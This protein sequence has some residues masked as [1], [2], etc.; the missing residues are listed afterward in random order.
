MPV[1]LRPYTSAGLA[2]VSATA[3]AMTPVV[4][5]PSLPDVKVANPAVQ[6]SAAVNPIEPWLQI[7]E[8]SETNVANLA[9]LWLEAP[10]PILQ[11]VIANQLGYLQQLPDFPVILEEMVGNLQAAL[12]APFAEDLS[13]LTGSRA[14]LYDIMMNGLGTI[15]PPGVPPELQPL[16]KFQTTYLSGVLLGLVGPVINPVLALGAS[17]HTIVGN[18]T[19][20]NPDLEAALNTLINTPAAMVDSFLNGGQQIDITPLVNALGIEH[21]LD[22]LTVKLTFGGLLSGAGTMFNALD[23][24][25]SDGSGIDGIGPGFV[26]SLIALTQTIAKAIGWDGEGNPLAPALNAPETQ[27]ADVNDPGQV[28]ASVLASQ[29][30]TLPTAQDKALDDAATEVETASVSKEPTG[31]AAVTEEEATEEDVTEEEVTEEEV[32]EEEATEDDLDTDL[33]EQNDEEATGNQHGVVRTNG[34][35]NGTGDDPDSADE[36]SGSDSTDSGNASDSE[37]DGDNGKADSDSSDSSEGSSG[38]D[39]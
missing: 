32:T 2:L 22:E 10:A 5:A 1:T 6:L 20:E 29:T 30:V 7:W 25:F 27:S 38:S 28:P 31:P 21:P 15:L 8:T 18:L 39:D 14:S 34:P 24:T 13:T 35:E 19:G 16:F 37:A 33:L 9:D 17:I 26:G 12:T 3:I 36:Q 23:F 4:A 11:Q